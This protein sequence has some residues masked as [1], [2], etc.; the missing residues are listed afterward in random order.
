MKKQKAK[1]QAEEEPDEP[2]VRNPYLGMIRPTAAVKP[3]V[4]DKL[5]QRIGSVTVTKFLGAMIEWAADETAP[6]LNA[7]KLIKQLKA[8]GPTIPNRRPK[9]KG[10]TRTFPSIKTDEKA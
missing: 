1:P 6:P 10:G 8:L 5:R 4:Y 7:N 9:P 3:E 2:A